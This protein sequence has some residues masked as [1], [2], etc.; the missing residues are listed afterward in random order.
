MPEIS[1]LLLVLFIGIVAGFI[2]ST[3]GGGGLISIPSLIFLGLPP[4]IAIATDR[5][6]CIGQSLAALPKYW[7]A[8]KIIWRYVPLFIIISLVSAIIGANILLN[9]NQLALQKIIGVL[10]LI[11][12][13]ILFLKP[14]SGIRSSNPSGWK[15]ILGLLIYFLIMIFG[16]FFGGGVGPLILYTLI[17]LFGFTVIEVNATKTIPW[18]L[19]ALSSFIIFALNGIVDYQKGIVLFVGMALGGY[20]GAHTALKKGDLWVKRLFAIIVIVSSI[21]LLFF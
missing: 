14:K 6:G 20:L 10:L 15:K 18:F 5:L 12:L 4:Q 11:L 7:R 1:T 8:K 3:V 16:G 13:I 2:D 9:I 17:F 19:L 21:K